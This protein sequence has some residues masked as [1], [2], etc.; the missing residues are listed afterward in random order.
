MIEFNLDGTIITANENFLSV[1]GYT[2]AEIQG[3]HHSMFTDPAE[4]ARPEYAAFWQKLGRGEFDANVYRRFAKGGREMWIQASYNPIFDPA[5]K[6]YKVV[7]YASDVTKTIRTIKIAE[8]SVGDLSSVAAAVEEMNS[9]ISEISRNMNMSRQASASILTDS[10]H[11][12]AAAQLLNDKMKNMKGI[13][14][15]ISGI[16]EQV[17]L[18]ALNATIEAARAGD[19]GKAFAV[20]A[21]EV[22]NL[23]TQ[24]TRAT[25]DISR[26]IQEVQSSSDDV[27]H[28][29]GNIASSA[30]NVDQYVTG[31]ASA[32]EE[33]TAVTKEISFNVQKV[34]GSMQQITDRSARDAA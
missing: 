34:S 30:G 6:P 20:V 5:G 24:T 19:A 3:R 21:A 4:A 10:T 16:A 7:K 29:I 2:L 1:T 31:A 15:L 32:I 12:S 11:S 8:A 18:L 22:K 25:E 14:E 13:I 9:S 17:N 26:Q 27:L 28:S 33:Q 23:A